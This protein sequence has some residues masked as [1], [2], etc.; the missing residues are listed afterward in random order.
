MG[1]KKTFLFCYLMVSSAAFAQSL[2]EVIEY[3]LKS[4]PILQASSHTV[5][6]AQAMKRQAVAGYLP[7]IDLTLATGKETSNNTT[8]RSLGLMDDR[9]TRTE[10][11][12]SISQLLYD[13]FATA[14]FVKQQSAVLSATESRLVSGRENTSLQA[15]QA[16][17]DIIRLDKMV[18]LTE[19]NLRFHMATLEK[20]NKRFETGVG[21]KVDVVQTEGRKAQSESNLHLSRKDAK[22]G[23]ARFYNI[24]GENAKD[25]EMPA[26]LTELPFNLEEALQLA[27]NNNSQLKAATA[28][29]EAA[30]AATKQAQA[31]LQPRFDLMLTATRN[32]NVDG[33]LGPNDDETAVIKMTYN[34]YR[35]G[36][37]Q[38]KSN[39]A[40]AREFAAR[41]TLRS[42]K[43]MVLQDVTII[44]NNLEDIQRR[45]AFLQ[46]HVS[47]TEEVL[48]VYNEQLALGKRSLLDVLDI[49]NELLR[50]QASYLSA[51]VSL[52]LVQYRILASS[53]SLLANFGL[54]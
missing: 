36:A 11:G 41:E 53:S 35:G 26:A 2:T 15:I 9:F 12:L 50:A 44:W 30:E 19:H 32:D 24:V 1:M 16:F 17:L 4:N 22:N 8:T 14:N 13:G 48:E 38:A 37:D 25:L 6:A 10:R 29:V 49:Q 21:T 42:V 40:Q 47:A 39:E 33:S 46:T 3:T 20:I 34:L 45:L 7:V 27:Y 23:R 28:D 43:N 51:E 52:R 5:D 31:S 18:D 54:D